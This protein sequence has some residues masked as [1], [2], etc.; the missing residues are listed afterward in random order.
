MFS[1]ALFARVGRE[2]PATPVLFRAASLA[3]WFTL[4][5]AVLYYLLFVRHRHSRDGV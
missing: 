4:L 5:L 3:M 2:W 1:P